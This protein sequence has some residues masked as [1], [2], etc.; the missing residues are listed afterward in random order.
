MIKNQSSFYQGNF[1]WRWKHSLVLFYMLLLKRLSCNNNTFYTFYWTTHGKKLVGK[2]SFHVFFYFCQFFFF[3]NNQ[4]GFFS[5]SSFF[6]RQI[7]SNFFI[8]KK[9]VVEKWSHFAESSTEVFTFRNQD[10]PSGLS[11]VLQVGVNKSRQVVKLTQKS[12]N[13]FPVSFDYLVTIKKGLVSFYSDRNLGGNN[14]VLLTDWGKRT[15]I[16]KLQDTKKVHN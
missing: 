15:L 14:G 6:H 11:G 3:V 13:L 7:R 5:T 10:L 1:L 8:R 2:L 16:E 9:H 4:N 12:K